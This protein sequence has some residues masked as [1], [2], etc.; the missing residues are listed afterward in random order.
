MKRESDTAPAPARTRG[1][2]LAAEQSNP[3]VTLL[4]SSI[5]W[6]TLV[7]VGFYYAIPYLP[8]EREFVAR[9]FAGHWIEYATTGLFFI[10]MAILTKKALAITTQHSVFSHGLIERLDL[11][12]NAS[13]VEKAA[14][15]QSNLARLP[16]K[17]RR[18]GLIQRI[19]NL[20]SYIEGRRKAGSV[21]DHLK[22][23]ADLAMEQLHGSYA[24]V[25]TVTW[26]IP[27]LGFLGTVIGI[28]MAIANVTPQQLESSLGEVTAGLAVAFDTTALSL[29]LSMVLVFATFLIEKA[30]GNILS[31]VEEF[32]IN[33]LASCFSE[34]G[35]P[36]TGNVFAAAEAE[37]A[38]QLLQGTEVLIRRQTSLWQESLEH[39]RKGWMES[40]EQ[41]QGR[42]AAALE[43]GM[44][45]T[46]DSHARQLAEVRGEFLN[47]LRNAA[48]EMARVVGTVEQAALSQQES[49]SRQTAELWRQVES[50]MTA[51][52]EEQRART[53][54]AVQL[55]SGAVSSW[56]D[57]LSGATAALTAHLQE[58]TRQGDA[59]RVIGDQEEQLSVLQG[60]LQ[61]NLDTVR[62]FEAFEETI[63][64]LNAAVHLLTIR[65]RPH[66]AAA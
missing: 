66:S 6:G 53:T 29:A 18:T 62:T 48:Q 2:E 31:R 50:Q 57:D 13:A 43:R 51:L 12:G 35:A 55:L 46:L 59:L 49:F 65:S 27:I 16:R 5:V 44:S 11:E 30:E 47:G 45:A 39:L 33:H 19:M 1:E 41:Q 22:Y 9:Y 21:D 64:S 54:E 20:C 23:L 37:A 58:L 38:Q 10:G 26:A 8:I 42:L 15:V 32:G 40:S 34:E 24:L 52:R 25:R 61:K 4:T 3:F 28:T 63:H 56:H 60:T 7:T 14:Q 17:W 36:E